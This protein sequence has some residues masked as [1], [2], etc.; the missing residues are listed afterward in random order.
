MHTV[1]LTVD[2]K[3]A[4]HERCFTGDI[5]KLAEK[6]FVPIT[7]LIHISELDPSANTNLYYKEFFHKIPS[8]HEI[9]MNVY[10]E[11]ERGYVEDPK[12]RG[13]IIQIAKDVLKSHRAKPTS[14]RAGC[15]ALQASDLKYLEDIG[16]IVDSSSVSGSDYKMF[17]DWAGGPSQPYHPS[18]E[19]VRKEGN[20]KV[21]TVPVTCANGKHAYINNTAD[22]VIEIL[23]ACEKQKVYCIGMRDYQ[24]SVEAL[25]KVIRYLRDKEAHFSTLTQCASEHYE[26]E[27][28]PV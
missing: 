18:H 15:F 11:N 9:G 22:D 16:V 5:I 4:H 20:A 26:H 24:D 14:F 23:N 17:V 19:D 10:F 12:E 1:V 28:H 3:A 13:N 8:W 6:H 21:L 27:L 7:W 25:D 2:C